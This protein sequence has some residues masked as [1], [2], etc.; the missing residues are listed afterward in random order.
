SDTLSGLI[1]QYKDAPEFKN[2]AEDPK[3]KDLR[4]DNSQNKPADSAAD[5]LGKRG[6]QVNNLNQ[7]LDKE[8]ATHKRAKDDYDAQLANAEAGRKKAQDELN[9]LNAAHVELQ[10]QK[11][12]A[13]QEALDS[14]AEKDKK[15]EDV[16]KGMANLTDDKEK[17]IRRLKGMI[18]QLE[19]L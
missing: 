2:I 15:I 14:M 16:T 1:G 8:K 9:K 12:K 6:S 13:Y 10:Q 4:W 19:T 7:Q 18:A 5:L 17:E 3:L 11:S